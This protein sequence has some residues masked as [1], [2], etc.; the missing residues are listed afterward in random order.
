[1]NSTS[2]LIYFDN[3]RTTV[4]DPEVEAEMQLYLS[5]NTSGSKQ[6][7][8][9][10]I[11]SAISYIAALIN[12]SVNELVF[13]NGTSHSI[14]LGIELLYTAR[15]EKTNHIITSH[16]EHPA[17]LNACKKLEQQGAI[18]SFVGVDQE[19]VIAND[20][21]VE[22]IKPETA[23]ICLMAANNETG[24][25]SPIEKIA[26][27][28]KEKELLFFCDAS[29]FVGKEHCDSKE[30]SIDCMAFGSH[31]M[32]G[33]KGVGALY[34]NED[35]LTKNPT[36]KNKFTELQLSTNLLPTELIIGFGKACEVAK[37][38]YWE[39]SAHI[40]KLRNYFEHQLLDVEG[41][42]INGSTR[43]RIYNTSNLFFPEAAKIL[44][45]K[46][47]YDFLSNH[48]RISKT[49]LAMGLSEED[50]HNSFRFSFGK[51]N[52]LE[53]VKTFTSEI[54]NLHNP[55]K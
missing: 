45:L 5:K 33:P 13:T 32:Y 24:V 9:T 55:E 30:L 43:Y 38:D 44:T 31:K 26:Q 6:I 49:L 15:K 41:L 53:E 2:N 12:G 3:N 4:I 29:Q 14:A 1:M 52:T 11:D 8:D 50:C 19:G 51:Y 35:C 25:L 28:C 42:R 36:L 16:S 17:V 48:N 27:L 39:I 54:L 18:L 46:N 10:S 37:R 7:P 34:I 47:K 22:L 40:S 20:Q 23:L 21:L